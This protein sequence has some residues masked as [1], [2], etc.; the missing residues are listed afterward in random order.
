MILFLLIILA[1]LIFYIF[2]RKGS[3]KSSLDQN[4]EIIYLK[5]AIHE[6][7]IISKDSPNKSVKDLLEDYEKR[8]KKLG[9]AEV[10]TTEFR[11][12]SSKPELEDKE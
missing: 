9:S 2:S 1:V 3:E 5:T 12:P 11:I 6:L 10:E 8:L 4:E 7:T